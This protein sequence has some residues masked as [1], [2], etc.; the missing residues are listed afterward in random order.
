[1]VLSIVRLKVA[2]KP[3]QA[4]ISLNERRLS[5]LICYCFFSIADSKLPNVYTEEIKIS[6]EHFW[7]HSV[8]VHGPVHLRFK[9]GFRNVHEIMNTSGLL[10]S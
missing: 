9:F 8:G 5:L 4:K 6:F 3:D 7:I 1:M 10:K 2:I